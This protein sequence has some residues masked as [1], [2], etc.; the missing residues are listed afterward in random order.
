MWY[1]TRFP[2]YIANRSELN[3]SAGQIN[4]PK[5]RILD[6]NGSIQAC[7]LL[8]TVL[9]SKSAADAA[10]QFI[11]T[12]HHVH[13]GLRCATSSW[14]HIEYSVA[15]A[16][17]T[18]YVSAYYLFSSFMLNR[19]SSTR[20]RKSRYWG[21][22]LLS[23]THCCDVTKLPYFLSGEL[24]TSPLH[25]NRLYVYTACCRR[26][27]QCF[28]VLRTRHTDVVG[29]SSGR[30]YVTEQGHNVPLLHIRALARKPVVL[31]FFFDTRPL[32]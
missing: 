20:V 27:G 2:W 1:I 16:C 23:P 32:D 13:W 21:E 3:Y 9:C 4:R 29:D 28:S 8:T 17:P 18:A 24:C 30:R 5:E 10:K 14:G 26:G 25:Y 6:V 31:I 22:M 7:L 15:D 11:F 12:L 19:D